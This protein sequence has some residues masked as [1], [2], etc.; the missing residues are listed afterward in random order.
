L[1]EEG[2]VAAL[3]SRCG[4]HASLIHGWKKTALEG[5]AAL[6]TPGAGKPARPVDEAQLATLCVK[7]GEPTVERDF[8][9]QEV[10]AR[11]AKVPTAMP[12]ECQT[13]A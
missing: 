10:R 3:S 5:L 13:R 7:I 8:F 1:R 4:V 12:L 11:L 9:S 2:T 6:F